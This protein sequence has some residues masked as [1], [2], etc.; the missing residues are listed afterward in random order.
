METNGPKTGIIYCRVSSQE[1][2][3]GTS[4]VMQERVCREYAARENIRVMACFVEEGESAKTTQRTE[5]QKALNF[6]SEK[7]RPVDFFIVH[8]LDRFARNLGGHMTTQIILRKYGTKLR[9][10][11]EQIDETPAG[12]LMEGV[13]ATI[14]E[15]DN[16]VRS[17]RSKSGMV[18]KTKKGIWVWAAPMGYVRAAKGGNL[19]VDETTAVYIK[20]AF[21]QYAYGGHTF[22]SLAK[23]LTE[24]GFRTRN[25]KKACPQLMEK[26]IRNPIYYGVIR[27]TWGEYPA[28]FEAIIDEEL[29]WRCQPG[30]RRNV[31]RARENPDFPL[32]GFAVC[33]DCSRSLTGSASTG[34]KGVKYPYYHHQ[35]Q[36]CAAARFIP[37]ETFEQ[38][39]VEYLDEITPGSRY[40]KVFKAVVMDVWKS[41]YK[42][43]DGANAK[44]RKTIETL[45]VER[46]RVFDLHINGTY[47]DEDFMR[48]KSRVNESIYAQRQF[49]LENHVEEFNMEEA[50]EYCFQFVRQSARQW[51]EL[52]DLPAH[53]ARF[54]NQIFPEKVT[55]NGKKFGTKKMS[56]V[57]NMNQQSGAD[58]SKLVTLRGFEPRFVP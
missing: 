57:Y 43:L 21:E 27:A 48:Q 35:I 49:L 39:F 32:R 20:M 22:R 58:K 46:Q 29:F 34:R 11:S 28:A 36:G 56:M 40:E 18:E 14:A 52:K 17:Q 24:R 1:Q 19:I 42:K 54:Q 23:L 50:L 45:E 3:A 37:S 25:G 53:R 33:P 31:R 26:I 7:K 38:N 8:K 12:Q 13:L 6:C 41:N 9:S 44:I 5:F 30:K 15:F 4:L 2:V 47:S 51:L 16:N 10:V 55:Y